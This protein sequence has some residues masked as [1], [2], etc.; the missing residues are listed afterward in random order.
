MDS[1]I[2]LVYITWVLEA[3]V[4]RAHTR[5]P[6]FLLGSCRRISPNIL[7]P[8]KGGRAPGDKQGRRE[9]KGSREARESA[10]ARGGGLALLDRALAREWW[11]RVPPPSF[12][13]F[14]LAT[15]SAPEDVETLRGAVGGGG[16]GI[17]RDEGRHRWERR[18]GGGPGRGGAR[19]HAGE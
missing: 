14:V 18:R 2:F 19:E 9:R 12:S 10:R 13:R 15:V 4:P 3:E 7:P 11:L 1:D 6:V 8:G 5:F 16:G 17:G